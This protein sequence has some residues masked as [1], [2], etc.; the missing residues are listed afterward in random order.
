MRVGK[1]RLGRWS[2]FAIPLALGLIVV[3]LATLGTGGSGNPEPVAA[4]GP[5]TGQGAENAP[6]PAAGVVRTAPESPSADPSSLGSP[7]NAAPSTTTPLPPPEP[8]SW[9]HK[10]GQGERPPQFVLFSFDGVGSH[11]HWQR[12]LPLARKVNARFTGL[13][14]GLYLLSDTDKARYTGPG[15]R[16]GKSSV[17]FGGPPEEVATRIDDLNQAIEQ[18]HEIGT[19][20]NGHFCRGAE[21]SGGRWNAEQWRSETDQFFEFVSRAPGLRIDPKTIKGGRTPCLEVKPEA[22]FPMLAERGMTYDTS[23]VSD[24]MVWP[25]MEHGV[26]EFKMPTVRVPALNRK[27][28]LM[29]F[30]MWTSLNGAKEQPGRAPE[31]HQDALD[32]YRAAYGA[33]FDGNRAPLVVGNHFNSW[34]AGAFS[35]AAEDFMGEVCV[36]PDT[37]CATYSEVIEWM[38]L[39]DPAVLDELRALPPSQS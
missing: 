1:H 31:L 10:L 7:T 28:I 32:A 6:A 30:N 18:G 8:R 11:E 19:H 23:L 5:D 29:D 16:P 38:S 25:R 12:K 17:G 13:L 20:F 35:R 14:T 15:H 36:K 21:P 3:L 33:V 4:S 27:V 39:Q 34:N 26:W 9:M 2:L 22:L 37:A 24:G